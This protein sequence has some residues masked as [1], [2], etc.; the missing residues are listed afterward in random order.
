MR[1]LVLVLVLALA[2]GLLLALALSSGAKT[3][4]YRR[5]DGVIVDPILSVSG[6]AHP[7]SGPNL[8]PFAIVAGAELAL[9]DLAWADLI[10]ADM[11]FSD[12]SGAD[13]SGAILFAT[14]LSGAVYDGFTLFPAGGDIYS[15]SWGLTGGATPW[16]LGMVPA[17]EPASGL[18]LG[19]GSI[20][21]AAIARR[22]P[23]ARCKPAPTSSLSAPV[24]SEVLAGLSMPKGRA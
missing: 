18:M 15:G 5:S 21:L 14:D 11:R 17:P 20:A 6:K 8:Q 9:A 23:F 7:Y 16:D 19:I 10:G 12:L 24:G 4:W 22:R 13:L 1:V 3:A 2:A